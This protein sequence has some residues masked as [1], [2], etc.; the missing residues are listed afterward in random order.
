MRS[1][2]VYLP[3]VDSATFIT[4]GVRDFYWSSRG[5]STNASGAAIPSGYGLGFNATGVIPSDGPH[6][7]WAGFP[8]RCLST[9]L[10]I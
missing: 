1:G 2:Y 7:R 8:L 10:D 4:A 3:G 6:E 9:V 5:S